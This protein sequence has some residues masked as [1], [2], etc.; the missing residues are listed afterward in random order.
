MRKSIDE[1]REENRVVLEE[2]RSGWEK[3]TKYF[4]GLFK[5]NKEDLK[6]LRKNL[7]MEERKIKMKPTS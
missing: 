5:S 4:E 1:N 2:L 7:R 6:R 3:L